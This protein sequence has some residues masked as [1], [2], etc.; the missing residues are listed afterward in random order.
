MAIRY[1]KQQ[2]ASPFFEEYKKERARLQS[3]ARSAKAR[4]I[5]L[6]EN[7][8]PKVPKNIRAGSVRKLQRITPEHGYY[9][10][11]KFRAV[12]YNTGEIFESTRGAKT[13]IERAISKYKQSLRVDLSP[14]PPMSRESID[15]LSR[16]LKEREVY[17]RNQFYK[18]HHLEED[19]LPTP[20]EPEPIDTTPQEEYDYN[21][22]PDESD[23]DYEEPD[24][25]EYDTD[26]D[27]AFDSDYSDESDRIRWTDQLDRVNEFIDNAID[28]IGTNVSGHMGDAVRDMI[29][30]FQSSM[31]DEAWANLMD[32]EDFWD[33]I[34]S[35]VEDNYKARKDPMPAV[36]NRISSKIANRP[37]TMEENTRYEDY[38]N[39]DDSESYGY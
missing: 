18:K 20:A 31:S 6:P 30:Q 27:E 25:S 36:Y 16:E 23:Y 24:Y 8:I 4:G 38:A 5:E 32:D 9:E 1:T 37:M 35:V 33:D 14:T 15:R 13:S 39:E 2:K 17:S 10:R 22:E 3:F 26:F 21:Y 11:A 7:F 12:D 29:D 34:A 19:E 28:Y